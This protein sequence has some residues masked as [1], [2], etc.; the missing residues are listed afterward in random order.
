M[1]VYIVTTN[2]ALYKPVILPNDP[3]VYAFL[4]GQCL[5]G[6]YDGKDIFFP[7]NKITSILVFD[8]EPEGREDN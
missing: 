8:Q 4:H 1:K 5:R 7:K 2:D 6:K 3:N